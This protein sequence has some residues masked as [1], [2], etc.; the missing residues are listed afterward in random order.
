MDAIPVE[1][2]NLLNNLEAYSRYGRLVISPE[3]IFKKSIFKVDKKNSES[4]SNAVDKNL[5][6]FLIQYFI[7]IW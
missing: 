2:I 6:F 5:I 7:N 3:G 4:R 1:I